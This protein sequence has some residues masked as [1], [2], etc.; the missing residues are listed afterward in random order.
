MY[1]SQNSF[2]SS[3][4]N[5]VLIFA[6]VRTA[7]FIS[8]HKMV[9]IENSPD[10]YK[11]VKISIVTIIKNSEMLKF[12]RDHLKNK[13]TCKNAVKRLLFVRLTK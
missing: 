1:S 10:N 8:L 13:K 6:L 7:S 12:V 2:F 5:I 11:M 3:Y 4:R 9:E